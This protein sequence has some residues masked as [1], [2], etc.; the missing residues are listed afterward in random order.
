MP[1]TPARVHWRVPAAALWLALLVAGPAD[2][3]STRYDPRL[4][5][6]TVTTERFTIYFH[7]REEDLARRLARIAEDVAAALDAHLG[8]PRSR[9][10]VILVDQ[11]DQSNGWATVIPYNLIEI[12]AAP[13]PAHSV[14]GNTDDWLRT[15][16]AHEYTHVVHLEKSG[17]W[18]GSLRHVFGRLPLFYANLALPDWQIEGPATLV[19]SALAGLGRIE[20]GDFRMILERAAADGR[21]APLDRAGG[22]L[23]DWPSGNSPYLYGGFFHD[24][25]ARTYGPESLERLADETASRLPF[26]G[27]RAFR[28]VYGRSLGELWKD[29]E[30]DARSSAGA[31]ESARAALGPEAR[32]ES[33]AR[34]RLTHHGFTVTAPLFTRDG[35][36]FYSIVDPHGFPALMELPQD[37]APRQI[38]TR[39]RGNR[40]AGARDLLVFD[41]LEV[42]AQVELQSDLYAVP[43]A[44][45]ATRRLTRHAR[46]AD[47][48]VAP[49]GETIVCTVQETGRR[50]LATLKLP[51]AGH[52]AEPVP[53]LSEPST[54][55]SSPRWS[56]DGRSIAA[57][58]RRLGGPSE[59]VLVDAATRAVRVVVSS[60]PAR[61]TTPAWLPDGTLLFSSDRDG[62]PFT[63]YAV[64]PATGDATRV[65]GAGEGAQ[66]PALSPDRRRLVFV[67]YSADG[68][69]LYA[70]P[71]DRASWQ[72]AAFPAQSAAEATAAPPAPPRSDIAVDRGPYRPWRTLA[73][74]VWLPIVESDGEDLVVGAATAGSDALGRHLYGVTLGW[75]VD[76][77]R[78][79]AQI[80]YAYARWRPALFASFATDTDPW[81]TG[82][83]RSREFM[84]GAL[85]P[86]RRV[87]WNSTAM[88]A[89]FVSSDAVACPGCGEAIESRSRRSAVRAGWRLSN[90]K[91]FGYS[92]SA[93]EG[94][95]VS[96]ASEVTRRFLGAD[97]DA[98]AVVADARHYLRAFP[99]HAV[100]A[101]RIA[102]AASWGD[103]RLRRPFGAGGSDAQPGGFGVDLGAIGL[104]RGFEESD[105]IGDRA[106]VVNVDYRFPLAWV[107]RGLGTWPVFLR[108]IH[109]ALFADA[110]HAWDRS[111]RSADIRRAFGG[112]VSFDTA[113]G[114][115][116]GMT[117]TAGVA[118]RHD[119]GGARDVV[120]FGRIGRA[121]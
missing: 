112:E 94:S 6:R 14:I 120:A 61:N 52:V 10:H 115:A 74:R 114:S 31:R 9:V 26:L 121:F 30:A 65:T 87:R 3:Q 35:R 42:V 17:G 88:A 107:Q 2:A 64:D 70:I 47:P 62:G 40:L 60:S 25:L 46:A 48:D 23:I 83:I 13:P 51:Q 82:E 19:E 96:I 11:T 78:P 54:E 18:L 49:D 92:I 105:V 119:S 8:A 109:G 84:T 20:A 103:A 111:F 5:F 71:F 91:C 38:A 43:S 89:L 44:G 36:L 117:I 116:V 77:R 27:S 95:S 15:V 102:G 67:G 76:R 108:S 80:D 101:A 79:D 7:Q 32:G 37:G 29:F 72:R 33:A 55:F 22:A 50:I 90:A 106:A 41:Q 34:R 110:G 57:E 1:L 12:A 75:S 39:Y 69:D 4:Q 28:E 63:L 59:I 66:A 73:P 98:G 85:F 118:W 104:L 16:F 53:L 99:R 21:F 81:R 56:P 100:I 45:G 58:R 24:Y 68:Y 86:V 113:F 93:E 97:A